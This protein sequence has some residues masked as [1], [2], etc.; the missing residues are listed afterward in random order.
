MKSFL[1][2][3]AVCTIAYATGVWICCPK[4]YSSTYSSGGMSEREYC[5][6]CNWSEW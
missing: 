1:I 2:K 5:S 3:V 6:K 4:C